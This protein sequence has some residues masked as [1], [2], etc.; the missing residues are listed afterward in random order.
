MKARIALPALLLALAPL[1]V[2]RPVIVSGPSMEPA[3]REGELRWALRAWAAGA[4]KRGEVW[5]VTG[6][7]GT[8]LKRVVGLPGETVVL[9]G[10]RLLVDARPLEEPWIRFPE[11][12]DQGPWTC[13]NGYLLLGD[14]RTVSVDGRRWGPLPRS[15]FLARLF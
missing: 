8:S 1:L 12:E 5:V 9:K 7:S 13:G 15:A 14:H 10:P 4:P 11:L 3:F 2:L 6:P